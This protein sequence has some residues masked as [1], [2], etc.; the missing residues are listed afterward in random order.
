M[1]LR[2][3]WDPCLQAKS[4]RAAK[5]AAK[6]SDEVPPSPV[7]DRPTSSGYM[8]QEQQRLHRRSTSGSANPDMRRVTSKRVRSRR[9]LASQTSSSAQARPPCCTSAPRAKYT[10][11]DFLK[12]RFTSVRVFIPVTCPPKDVLLMVHH[13]WHAC[14]PLEPCQQSPSSASRR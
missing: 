13:A 8:A 6:D 3:R 1:G 2:S 9:R 4:L 11:G 7:A 12:G 5:Q 10:P 14:R